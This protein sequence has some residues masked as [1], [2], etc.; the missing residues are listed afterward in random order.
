MRLVVGI[1]NYCVSHFSEF[2]IFIRPHII[3]WFS[4]INFIWFIINERTC[5]KTVDI[6]QVRKWYRYSCFIHCVRT[7][8]FIVFSNCKTLHR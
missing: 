5:I 7:A 3:I 8:Q 1:E 2:R 6:L 4:R